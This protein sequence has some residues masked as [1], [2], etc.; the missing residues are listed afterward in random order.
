MT[1]SETNSFLAPAH[2]C[3]AVM[4]VLEFLAGLHVVLGLSVS[5]PSQGRSLP[6]CKRKTL[7]LGSPNGHPSSVSGIL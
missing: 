4:D 1:E 7:G 3:L 5:P 2:L 6:D